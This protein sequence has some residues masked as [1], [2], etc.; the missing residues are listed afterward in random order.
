MFRDLNKSM[1]KKPKWLRPELDKPIY[2]VHIV[3]LAV[4]L[5]YFLKFAFGHDMVS[6]DWGWKIGLGLIVADTVAHT[7]LGFD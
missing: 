7:V 1:F 2:Y 6:F 5:L 3:I 4:I